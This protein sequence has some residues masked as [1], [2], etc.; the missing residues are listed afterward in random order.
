MAVAEEAGK[1][2]EAGGGRYCGV[3]LLG[4]FFVVLCAVEDRRVSSLEKYR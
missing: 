4:V 2:G 1:A 3:G